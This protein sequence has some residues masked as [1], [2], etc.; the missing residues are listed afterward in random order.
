[1]LVST[2]KV[3]LARVFKVRHLVRVLMGIVMT[4]YMLVST[5][6]SL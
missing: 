2:L 1:M 3:A 6:G 5:C 4:V